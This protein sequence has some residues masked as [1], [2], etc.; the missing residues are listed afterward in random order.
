MPKK[1]KK[2]DVYITRK[3]VEEYINDESRSP[4]TFIREIFMYL[5]IHRELL[6]IPDYRRLYDEALEFW[7][8]EVDWTEGIRHE[9]DE[10]DDMEFLADLL[11]KYPPI[12]DDWEVRPI[13]R[14]DM[15]EK[16]DQYL[17]HRRAVWQ[18]YERQKEDR[19][20]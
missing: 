2:L 6:E 13:D 15:R 14:P 12:L 16:V 8:N 5:R 19:C 1:Q 11:I 9:P 3:S 20:V 18:S 4:R 10:L 17:N 7:L